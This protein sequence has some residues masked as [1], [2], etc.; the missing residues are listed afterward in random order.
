MPLNP[1]ERTVHFLRGVGSLATMVLPAFYL[2]HGANADG[3]Q[4]CAIEGYPGV[5]LKHAIKFSS[6]GTVSLSCRKAFDH[7]A[8]GLTGA[9][10]A[11]NSDKTLEGV[12]EYW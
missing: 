9:N 8:T 11:K 1:L 5:V 4:A 2:F 7:G 12:A 6:V 3:D 10:F